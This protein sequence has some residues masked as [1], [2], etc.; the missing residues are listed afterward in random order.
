VAML[1]W[2]PSDL[3]RLLE[4]QAAINGDDGDDE[5]SV[6]ECSVMSDEG[7][8]SCD[9][10]TSQSASVRRPPSLALC[11]KSA[12][13]TMESDSPCLQESTNVGSAMHRSASCANMSSCFVEH[14]QLNATQR[15]K[16]CHL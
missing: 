15:L 2:V 6:I 11:G 5:L 4:E 3:E 13:F 1:P 8:A 7:S 14:P 12:S 9:I 10:M 16:V